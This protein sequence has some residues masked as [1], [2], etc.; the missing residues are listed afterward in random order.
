[1]F[2]TAQKRIAPNTSKHS[3]R[4]TLAQLFWFSPTFN[5]IYPIPREQSEFKQNFPSLSVLFRT[6]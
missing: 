4:A 2:K 6:L 5:Q 1:M 3:H